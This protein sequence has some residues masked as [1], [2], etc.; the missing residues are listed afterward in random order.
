MYKPSALTLPVSSRA[1]VKAVERV[2]D[3]IMKKKGRDCRVESRGV[4][5]V[6]VPPCR[7]LKAVLFPPDPSRRQRM[8]GLAW[9]GVKIGTT[10]LEFL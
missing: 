1:A 5:A 3:N 2:C 8:R 9:T 4:R 6:Y 7:S 10:R